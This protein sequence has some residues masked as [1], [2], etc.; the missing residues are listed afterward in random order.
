MAKPPASPDIRFRDKIEAAVAAGA[1][2]EDLTLR[3]TLR[4]VSLL[5]RDPTVPVTDISYSDGVMRFL[6]VKVEKGGVAVSA[7]DGASGS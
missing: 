4:D 1:A 3:L 7:L 2:R 5:S 6:G